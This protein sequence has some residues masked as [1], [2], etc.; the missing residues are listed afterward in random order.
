MIDWELVSKIIE[1]ID[2][3]VEKFDDDDE[4]ICSIIQATWLAAI[5]HERNQSEGK[6]R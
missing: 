2:G 3:K 6:H 1:K 5:E 4:F